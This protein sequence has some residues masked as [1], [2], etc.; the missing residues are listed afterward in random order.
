MLVFFTE[1]AWNALSMAA[2]QADAGFLLTDAI[3]F[4]LPGICGL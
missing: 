3:F 2:L 1:L 4:L